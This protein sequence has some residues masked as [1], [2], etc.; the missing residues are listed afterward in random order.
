MM[1]KF[2][3][4]SR[5]AAIAKSSAISKGFWWGA[6]LAIVGVAGLVAKI[7]PSKPIGSNVSSASSSSNSSLGG[8]YNVTSPSLS[9][10][11]LS[12]LSPQ[13]S[14]SSNSSAGNSSSSGVTATGAS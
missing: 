12:H 7:N 3:A 13:Q 6:L 8:G 1:E 10:P 11:P 2:T 9:A 4:R 14:G 5:D